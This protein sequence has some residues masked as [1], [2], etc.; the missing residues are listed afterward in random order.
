[1]ENW[2]GLA[3]MVL[4]VIAIA[5]LY[6]PIQG[7]IPIAEELSGKHTEVTASISASIFISLG[8]LAGVSLTVVRGRERG[9]EL[10]R[11]R[12]QVEVY[13]RQEG[14]VS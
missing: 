8:S 14:V 5:V 4:L 1:M 13:E 6:V 3:R 7:V 11:L 9:K 12:A 10:E 2:F